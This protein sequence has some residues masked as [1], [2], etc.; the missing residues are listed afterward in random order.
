MI[1]DNKHQIGNGQEN[2]EDCVALQK[3]QNQSMSC[4]DDTCKAMEITVRQSNWVRTS[5]AHL[6]TQRIEDAVLAR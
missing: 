2:E 1:G 5:A 3:S 4:L 6:S